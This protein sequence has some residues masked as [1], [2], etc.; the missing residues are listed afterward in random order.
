[1]LDLGSFLRKL[2]GKVKNICLIVNHTSKIGIKTK[3]MKNYLE[4]DKNRKKCLKIRHFLIGVLEK[5][6]IVYQQMYF[7]EFAS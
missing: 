1:M 4:I 5:K 2:R 6:Y 7:F 3:Y